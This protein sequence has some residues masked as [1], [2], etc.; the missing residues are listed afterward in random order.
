M[1]VRTHGLRAIGMAAVSLALWTSACNEVDDGEV[2]VLLGSPTLAS[3][4]TTV[5][6]LSDALQSAVLFRPDGSGVLDARVGLPGQVLTWTPLNQNRIAVLTTDDESLTILDGATFR[7]RRVDLP[8]A[9]D[10]MTASDDGRWLVLSY[11]P[12]SSGAGDDILFNPNEI[13]LVDLQA[14]DLAVRTL[15][16]TGP[17]PERFVFAPP[18]S[19]GGEAL[20]YVVA[21]GQSAVS[22]VDLLS[23]DPANVQRLV[24]LA[25]PASG[26]SFVPDTVVFTAD[27]AS[28]TDDMTAYTIVQ[29]A[30]QLYAIDLLPA[31]AES[32]RVLQPAVN[33]VG[34]GGGVSSAASFVV[35]GRQKLLVTTSSYSL[36]V[37]DVETSQVRRI[38]LSAS[39]LTAV[40]TY[41]Q[42]E[43][44]AERPRALL[45][46]PG[47]NVVYFAELDQLEAQGVGALRARA[48]GGRVAQVLLSEVAPDTA[49]I[50]YQSGGGFG[51][52]RLST[53]TEVPIPSRVTL[54]DYVP[55][56]NLV[57]ASVPG[58]ARLAV[59]DTTSDATGQIELPQPALSMVP[60]GDSGVLAVFH[61]GDYLSFIRSSDL[62]TGVFAESRGSLLEGVLERQ[63]RGGDQ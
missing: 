50:A 57:F 34:L 6:L 56:G 59:L 27:D 62:A 10:A 47:A 13:G 36:D 28:R 33:L 35:D 2:P 38:A 12:G 26:A 55:V 11:A 3:S 29:G 18:F 53:R 7:G 42:V 43:D 41:S 20:H 30:S 23:T 58:D 16:L 51:L 32:G 46:S 14:P 19:L 52:L 61:G 1:V 37:V 21:L 25:D 31:D 54:D 39:P 8:S 63:D 49:V 17:R 24:R 48:V 60:M 4:G 44:G 45:W 40:V 22:F 5:A 9:F 15:S